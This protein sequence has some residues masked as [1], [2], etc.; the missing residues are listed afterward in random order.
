MAVAGTG[1]FELSGPFK[2]FEVAIDVWAGMSLERRNNHF[3]R[4]L[5]YMP[6]SNS[7]T[8]IS[9]DGQLAV[10]GPGKNGGKKPSQRKRRKAAKTTTLAKKKY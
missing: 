8:V 1:D 6:L 5:R 9:T 2:K 3:K 7:N 10:T 4:F